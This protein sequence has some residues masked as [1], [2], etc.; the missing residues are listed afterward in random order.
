MAVLLVVVA[1]GGSDQG[2]TTASPATSTTT[3]ATALPAGPTE[4][5]IAGLFKLKTET[6]STSE[7]WTPLTVTP[8]T[9]GWWSRGVSELWLYLEYHEEGESVYDLDVAVLAHDPTSRPMAL[10]LSILG[11]DQVVTL[12][13]PADTTVDGH[14]AVVFDAFQPE[15]AEPFA[16]C[17]GPAVQGNS[18]FPDN[19][20]G[21]VVLT[22]PDPAGRAWNFGIRTCRTARIWVIDVDGSTITIIAST[23]DAAIFDELMPIAEELIAGILFS[24]L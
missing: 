24:R 20:S 21:T 3:S 4:M 23:T 17:P 19:L 9:D 5:P 12:S 11:E 10:A 18:R 14:P 16:A 1:C 2:V 15:L 8:A 22:A 7:F 6:Y 13:A